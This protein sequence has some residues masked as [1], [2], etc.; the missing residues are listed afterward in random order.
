[1]LKGGLRVGQ[2]PDCAAYRKRTGSR[3]DN[4][5]SAMKR[6]DRKGSR[7]DLE[8]ALSATRDLL[9]NAVVGSAE[10]LGI[11]NLYAGVLMARYESAGDLTNLTTVIDIMRGVAERTANDAPEWRAGALSNLGSALTKRW[12]SALNERDITEAIAAHEAAVALFAEDPASWAMHASNLGLALRARYPLTSDVADLDRAVGLCQQV[13]DSLPP[14]STRRADY[15]ANMGHA[16]LDRHHATGS[17]GDLS[18]AISNYRTAL[19]LMS[20]KAWSRGSTQ[21]ALAD[22]LSRQHD[23]DGGP[24]DLRV[25]VSMWRD[26]CADGQEKPPADVLKAACRWSKAVASWGDWEAAVEACDAGLA[27]TERLFRTQLLREHK[28]LWLEEASELPARAAYALAKLG[29]RGKAAVALERGRAVLLAE[30]LDQGRDGLDR[31]VAS[32]RGKLRERY[33]QAASRLADLERGEHERLGRRA[34]FV[35]PSRQAEELRSAKAGLEEALY[36]IRAVPGYEA[37]LAPPTYRD[38]TSAATGAPLAYVAYTDIGGVALIID[39]GPGAGTEPTVVWLDELT[40]TAVVAMVKEYSQSYDLRFSREP[41]DRQHWPEALD[42]TTRRLWDLVMGPVLS[43]LSAGRVVLIPGG[44]LGLLPLQAAWREDQLTVTGRRYALDDALITY[45]PSARALQRTPARTEQ[46]A[47]LAVYDPDPGLPNTPLEVREV[48]SWF[49]RGRQLSKDH[50]TLDT[51]RAALAE[52]SVLHFSCHGSAHLAD[53][54]Q[55]GL[56]AASDGRLTLAHLLDQR[57][58]HARLAV[59]SACETAVVG[60][61]VPDEAIG[62]PAGLIQAGAQGVIGSLWPVGNAVTCA[63]MARFY[64]LWRGQGIEP[65]E[66]L[67]QA[68]QW[69]RDSTIQA[70]TFAYP[71]MVWPGPMAEMLPLEPDRLVHGHPTNWAAFQYV[72]T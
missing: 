33:Q 45:T 63:L 10:Q 25:A 9:D 31:L 41:R 43:A 8:T 69:V 32:G 13:I 39:G 34:A 27:A 71:E 20:G 59:L 4:A 44:I 72:G 61:N 66:A 49:S 38:I 22:A 28:A 60:T 46:A 56:K 1:M 65:P 15:L 55:S 17:T 52:Y 37:F 24:D 2:P 68:Q 5:V 6:H 26:A 29:E 7:K 35:L 30:A 36:A 70:V 42:S 64:E 53:P 50:A 21:M 23:H 14:Q 62:L 48:L 16:L 54:L 47:I 11:L 67:R 57:L 51:V 40:E 12:Q 58:P 19:E 3:Y 18:S